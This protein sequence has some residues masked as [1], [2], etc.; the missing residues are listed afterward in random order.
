MR[1]RILAISATGALAAV[2]IAANPAAA[3]GQERF[4]NQGQLAISADIIEGFETTIDNQSFSNGGGSQ[5]EVRLA[6]AADYFVIDRLSLGGQV[7]FGVF[8]P[9]RGPSQTEFSVAPRIG[10]NAPINDFLSFWPDGFIRFTTVSGNPGENA[11]SIGA[12][13]PLMLHP[14]VHFFLGFGPFISTELSHDPGGNKLTEFGITSM[15]GGW[16]SL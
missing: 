13:A 11:F 12:F 4:G 3:Q 9:Q 10:Y 2:A 7:V 6:P 5:T 15:V 16:F 8:S 1:K 14:A